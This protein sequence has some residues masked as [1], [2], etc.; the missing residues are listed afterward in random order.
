MSNPALLSEQVFADRFA[1]TLPAPALDRWYACRSGHRFQAFQGKQVVAY[2]LERG[3]ANI[4]NTFE[5]QD[6]R[7]GLRS[8]V[9]SLWNGTVPGTDVWVSHAPTEIA[10]N[11]FLW[12]VQ[13]TTLDY[14]EHKGR[15]NTKFNLAY[16]TQANPATM[17]D[18][19]TYLLE[20]ATFQAY[21]PGTA[22]ATKYEE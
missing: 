20:Y 6:F 5:C 10:P 14:N 16:R 12:H 9:A 21:F 2:T 3:K 17:E 13:H 22:I 1:S 18:G 15:F 7:V 8:G 11:C 19:R 4:L